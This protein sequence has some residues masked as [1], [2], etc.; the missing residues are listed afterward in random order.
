MG[1]TRSIALLGGSF[2]PVHN[3]HVALGNYFVTLLAPD[4]LRL[5]PAG[6]PWQKPPLKA[7]AQ[8]RIAMLRLAFERTAVTVVIDEQE[9][10]RND[11]SYTIDTLRA[12]RSQLGPEVSLAFLIGGDQLLQLHTWK[13]W[14][15]LFDHA[16]ICAASRPGFDV[17]V[18]P[19]EVAR[20]FSRRGATAEQIRTTPHGLALLGTNLA[21]DISA[22]QIR[23]ALQ[24]DEPVTTLVPGGVLDYIQQHHLYKS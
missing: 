11:A 21:I 17:A 12:M 24:H 7:S 5:L 14:Q 13:D 6:N 18:L 10:H 22:T 15:A 4:E 19:P 1:V 16:H 23:A 20:E 8:Q 2:D 3:G 9:I